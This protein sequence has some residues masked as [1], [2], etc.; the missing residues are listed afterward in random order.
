MTD[1][2]PML[3]EVGAIMTGDHF[4]GTKGGHFDTYINKDALYPHI[5][6]VASVG[7]LF[8]Q[9]FKEYNVDVVAGPA[10]GGIILSQWTAAAMRELTGEKTLSVYA[11]KKDGG[12]KMTRGYD[13]VVKG[14]RVA[15][16]EDLTTTGGSLK[17]AIAAVQEA[18]GEV[19]VC[20]VMVNKNPELNDDF[21]GVPFKALSEMVVTIYEAKECAL[22]ASNVPV[23]TSIGH[24]KAF[25]QSQQ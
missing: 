19:V 3:K 5:D 20:G 7:E 6:K 15:V 25:V 4:V 9:A 11:E 13:Q 1:L 22:C 24:G 23:N 10:L 2:I 18:G 14:K 12:L 21:F 16:V 17:T 8:A